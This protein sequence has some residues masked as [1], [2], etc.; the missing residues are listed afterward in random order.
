[1]A[2]L[3]P[4]TVSLA[5]DSATVAFGEPIAAVPD[6]GYEPGATF[7]VPVTIADNPGFASAV[8]TLK[9]DTDAF[10]LT[11]FD[12]AG[13]IFEGG[14]LAPPNVEAARILYMRM[15]SNTMTNGA[16]FYADFTVKDDAPAGSYGFYISPEGSE[17]IPT[18]RNFADWQNNPVPVVYPTAY[19]TVKSDNPPVEPASIS[20]GSVSDTVVGGSFTVPVSI[21]DNPGF[22]A[23]AFTLDYDDT[24]LEI[25]SVSADGALF[26]DG[27]IW[28]A[29]AP[30]HIGFVKVDDPLAPT[31]VTGDGKLFDVTF[32]VKEGATPGDYAIGLALLDGQPKNFANADGQAVDAGFTPTSVEVLPPVPAISFGSPAPVAAGGSFTVPVNIKDNPGFSA[33]AFMLGFDA[34]VLEISSVSADG[35]LFAD[36]LIWDATTPGRVGFVKVDDPL[37]PTDVTGDGKL[38]DVTFKVKEGTTLGNYAIGLAL[39]DGQPK[40]FANADGQAVDVGFTSTSVKVVPAGGKASIWVGDGISG[41]PGR[42]VVVPVNIEDN[43]G[44][45]MAIFTVG[46]DKDVLELIGFD[47]TDAIVSEDTAVYDLDKADNIALGNLGNINASYAGDG[48]LFN[49]VFALKAGVEADTYPVSLSLKDGFPGNFSYYDSDWGPVV[50]PVEFVAGSVEALDQ[51]LPTA[52]DLDYILPQTVTYDGNSHAVTVGAKNAD[53]GTITVYY[54]G[55]GSTT[56]N[57]ST[58]APVDAGTYRVTVDV[59]AAEIYQA[60]YDIELGTLTIAK[61]AAPTIAWPTAGDIT[62]GQAL[63]ASVLSATSNA[64]GDFVWDASVDLTARPDAG[65]HEYLMAFM[66]SAAT[67]NNYE[68]ISPLTQDVTVTVKKAAAPTIAWPTAS[69]LKEGSALSAS[70]L[71]GGSTTYGAFGWVD[72]TVVPPLAGGSY[73]VAFTPSAATLNNYEVITQLEQDVS[74]VVWGAGDLD[75]DGYVTA[76]DVMYHLLVINGLR[77]MPT[78]LDKQLA[79]MDGDGLLTVTDTL[80]M[81]KKAAGIL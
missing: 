47:F 31:D 28:D 7:R 65:S 17:G 81:L 69:A 18:D 16:L 66:P 14:Q 33:A 22:S 1:M 19:F 24:A 63:S 75:N 43:P 4:A 2:N 25:S 32:K 40:N 34:S 49:M 6:G 44:F 79:D 27:L 30:D 67:L 80:M 71:T 20:L 50:I 64:Y 45:Y 52:D 23:A 35:A 53:M 39:L 3:V 54:T 57:R 10:E 37:T 36:G 76:S 51:M 55:S 15:G 70:A 73:P 56:Y 46:F 58:A 74:V 72:D 26:A 68:A 78:G 61:A 77:P 21:V 41:Y 60:A 11:G 8:F 48:V 42:E 13:T 62:Y 5:A 59:A 38:F 29:D 9:Y 12:L